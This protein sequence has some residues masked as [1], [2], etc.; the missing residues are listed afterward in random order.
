MKYIRRIDFS[1]S[2]VKLAALIASRRKFMTMI[3]EDCIR[4]RGRTWP[5]HTRILTQVSAYRRTRAFLATRALTLLPRVQ[6]SKYRSGSALWFGA[7]Q[8]RGAWSDNKTPRK[9]ELL[10]CQTLVMHDLQ[11][12]TVDLKPSPNGCETHENFTASDDARTTTE[13]CVY[14]NRYIT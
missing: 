5:E 13:F 6:L 7:Y 12:P 10:S 9:K 2:T 8:S 14:S 3:W 11:V 1:L 4:V